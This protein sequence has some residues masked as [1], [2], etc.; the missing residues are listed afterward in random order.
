MDWQSIGITAGAAATSVLIAMAIIRLWRKPQDSAAARIVQALVLAVMLVLA[1]TVVEPRWQASRLE[2]A[3][4]EVPVH[5]ALKEHHPEVYAQVAATVREVVMRK[6]SEEEAH[7]RTRPLIGTLAVKMWPHAPD[8]LAVRFGGFLVDSLSVLHAKG[9]TACF[10][11]IHA[12]SGE[13]HDFAALLGDELA[14]RDLE[15]LE[16]VIV[17]TS[18]QRRAPVS[19]AEVAADLDAVRARLASSYSAEQLEVLSD[20]EAPG[21]DKR[22]FCQVFADLYRGAVEL[23]S[24]RNAR[25]VRYLLQ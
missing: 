23:P 3:M 18:G 9:G 7:A 25:L 17:R 20:P 24:P 4:M 15:L 2:A 21:L 5:R 6:L 19:E 12:P 10:A 11:W 8:D 13:V 22:L 16:Q 14:G 1:K